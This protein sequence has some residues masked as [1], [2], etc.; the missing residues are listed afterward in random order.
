MLNDLM[1]RATQIVNILKCLDFNFFNAN[2]IEYIRR[3]QGGD[4]NPYI[5]FCV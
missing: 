4:H 1:P 5:V 3:Y 2:V